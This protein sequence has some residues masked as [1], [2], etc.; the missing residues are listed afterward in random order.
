MT[1]ERDVEFEGLE[2]IRITPACQHPAL[3]VIQLV[4]LTALDFG[5]RGRRAK[6]IQL[7]HGRIR[8][9]THVGPA[10]IFVSQTPCKK[11]TQT[12]AF[13]THAE[14]VDGA[15]QLTNSGIELLRCRAV[16]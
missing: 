15:R 3:R 4:G 6:T 8:Q 14:R 1:R 10:S 16:T 12:A 5:L 11:A 13:D 7:R 2:R 9:R